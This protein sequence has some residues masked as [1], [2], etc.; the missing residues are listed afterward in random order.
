[1]D[2]ASD[3]V[4]NLL[5]GSVDLH[6]HA[7]P[8]YVPYTVDIV[9]LISRAKELG[10]KAIVLK[11]HYYPTVALARTLNM[12]MGFEVYGSLTLNYC[13]GG[14]N[15]NAVKVGLKMGA[16][17]I[18][19]PTIDAWNHRH[20][21]REKGGGL[22]IL[23]IKGDL[24]PEVEEILGLIADNDLV[25]ATGHLSPSEVSILVNEAIHMGVK[26]IMVTHPIW[27][28]T[29]MTGKQITRLVNA[30]AYIELPLSRLML[31]H[32]ASSIE[33]FIKVIREASPEHCILTSDYGY[34]IDIDPLG[35]W[36]KCLPLL[37]EKGLPP[38]DLEVMFKRNPLSLISP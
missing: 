9:K 25:L 3:V 15:V 23:S 6:V 34:M 14:F 11:S 22:S 21:Y 16:K 8:D 24:L 29:L 18:W 30:G 37:L 36:F 35:I 26:R 27:G 20:Y 2:N 33:A 17:V 7:S 5:R 28:P 19:M 13:I 31:T 1:M 12:L 10:L 4:R 38:D 32:D